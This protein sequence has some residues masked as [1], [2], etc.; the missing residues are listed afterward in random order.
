MHS[1]SPCR[2]NRFVKIHLRRKDK[3]TMWDVTVSV[4]SNSRKEQQKE[5]TK[6]LTNDV[7]TAVCWKVFIIYG[8][9][10]VETGKREKETKTIEKGHQKE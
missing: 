8:K 2:P 9:K 1:T 3:I 10:N 5:N 7:E 4:R 6:F